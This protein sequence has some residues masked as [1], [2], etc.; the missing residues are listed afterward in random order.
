M[1]H[2]SDSLK[3][4]WTI[5]KNRKTDQL[6]SQTD[7]GPM[8]VKGRTVTESVVYDCIFGGEVTHSIIF[9]ISCLG[10][11]GHVSLPWNQVEQK[12]IEAELHLTSVVDP[13]L[14]NS[15]SSLT[16]VRHRVSLASALTRRIIIY[17]KCEVEVSQKLFMLWRTQNHVQCVVAING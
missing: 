16:T 4:S 2:I 15:S 12:L 1:I 7:L 10:L 8:N 13:W 14:H 5:I 11:S 17:N 9:T 3:F 6:K